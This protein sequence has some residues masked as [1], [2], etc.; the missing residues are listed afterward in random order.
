M[1]YTTEFSGA[2]TIEPPLNEAEVSFLND[3]RGTR[4]MKRSGGPY[5]VKGNG[6]AGQDD[7]PDVIQDHNYPPDGQP[8]LWCHWEATLDGHSILW[9]GGEKFYDSAE[10]MSY[11]INHFLKP[12]A[13]ASF[14]LIA[15]A[16]QDARFLDFTF[17]HVVNGVIDAEGEDNSDVWRLIVEDN[18]VKT[19]TATFSF[20]E[21]TAL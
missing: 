19:S 20:S 16:R 15:S 10:W 12:N 4:R 11:I 2:V 17:D 3:F 7:G 8:G 6:Y 21:P 18:I 9:D 5:F 1:G 14:D 13:V